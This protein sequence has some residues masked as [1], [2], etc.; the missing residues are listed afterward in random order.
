MIT[1]TFYKFIYHKKKLFVLSMIVIT[2]LSSCSRS[3]D[4]YLNYALRAAGTNRSQLENVLEHY[5]NDPEKMAATRFLI[6][7][8]PGHESYQSEEI[9]KYYDIAREVLMSDLKPVEQRDSLLHVSDN[10]FRGMEYRTVS[11]LKTIKADYLIHSIDQAFTQWKTRPWTRHLTFDEF[12]EWI[13]PYKVVEYQELDYWRDEL[14]AAFQVYVDRMIKDDDQ[15][16][17]VFYTVDA[18]R[19]GI[20]NRVKPTGMYNRS[21]YPLLRADLL[22]K[23]TYG[24]WEDYGNLGVMTY[25]SLGLP[26]VID[27]TPFWGRYR[28]GHS[29]YVILN[30]RGEELRSEWDVGS[31]P[32]TAFFQDKRIPKVYRKTYA[33]NR[34]RAFYKIHSKYKYPFNVCCKDVTAQYFRTSDIEITLFDRV[35]LIEDWAYIATFTG[36]GRD[37]SIVDYGTVKRGKATF[38]NMGRNVLYIALGFDGNTLVPVSEPFILHIDGSLQFISNDWRNLRSVNVRRKY[39][40]SNNVVRMRQRLIG[41]AIQCSNSPNFEDAVT[42]FTVDTLLLPDKVK[43]EAQRPYRYWRYLSP[44]GSYGSIAELAFFN[45]DSTILLGK[46]ISSDKDFINAERAFDGDWLTNFE[47]S[48]ENGSWVGMD[49]GRPVSVNYVRIVPR[50]D[51]NDIHPGDLYE[52]KYW[53]GILAWVSRG[54]QVAQDNTLTFDSIPNGA[55]IWLSNKT[56]GWDERPF[57]VDEYGN[58][59]WW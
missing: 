43:L 17:T 2:I 22:L 19:N 51:D 50:G 21:G 45:R 56:R 32:G 33:I 35:T 31:V 39:F 47:T 58:V 18:V 3:D 23:Q 46:A 38:R 8:M 28:A 54:E 4:D 48:N 1:K 36:I 59:E 20:L 6:E 7:N 24:R 25:R 11:D 57:M 14:Q 9:N 15:Y 34:D 26:T 52:L 30:D 5:K 55:L 10:Q 13:L 41:G 12:C 37:W 40:Q 27:Q 53:D 49:M 44:D 29:W 42:L 16:G